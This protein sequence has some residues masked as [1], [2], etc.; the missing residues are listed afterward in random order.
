MVPVFETAR[1]ILR[2]I[3]LD[4]A[5]AVQEL[6]PHWEIVRFLSAKVPWPYPPDGALQFIR[7]VALPAMVRGEQWI[8]AIRLKSGP[9][10]LIGIVNLTADREENRGFWLGI[11]WQGQGLMS[12]ACEAVTEFWFNS[13][14]RELLLVSKAGANAASRRVSE[15]EG[16]R[17]VAVEERDYVLGRGPAEIWELTREEWN[18]RRRLR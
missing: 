18:G 8:W 14:G 10:H 7:D 13:L 1:L 6:F 16:A 9:E 5:G 11:P 3:G 2:P 4:D 17:L 15:R 12:E